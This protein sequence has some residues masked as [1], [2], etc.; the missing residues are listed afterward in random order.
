MFKDKQPYEIPNELLVKFRITLEGSLLYTL[1]LEY[2]ADSFEE[3]V[4]ESFEERFA[5]KDWNEI[6][7][8]L[9]LQIRSKKKKAWKEQALKNYQERNEIYPT[10]LNKYYFEVVETMEKSKM[11]GILSQSS[12]SVE[13]LMQEKIAALDAWASDDTKP[14]TDYPFL[15]DKHKRSIKRAILDDIQYSFLHFLKEEWGKETGNDKPNKELRDYPVQTQ[16]LFDNKVHR[17]EMTFDGEVTYEGEVVPYKEL[18]PEKD[19]TRMIV[20]EPLALKEMVEKLGITDSIKDLDH[21]D[22]EIISSVL[23]KRT[24]SFAVN[25]TIQLSLNDIVTDVFTSDSGNNYRNLAQ[26]MINLTK[27][28]FS[29]LNKEN[30]NLRVFG[31]FD[32]I[33]F[34]GE[35][36]MQVEVIINKA[37]HDAYINK[38]T[39]RIYREQLEKLEMTMWSFLLFIQK[40]RITAH[41]M[42]RKTLEVTLDNF[43]YNLR[44]KSKRKKEIRDE[45]AASLE[46]LK[47][48]KL[49]IE[50][51][52]YNRD[53]YYVTFIPMDDHE[54]HDIVNFG[55]KDDTLNLDTI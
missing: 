32:Y 55:S 26:R 50:D 27:M 33:E 8:Y 9:R 28:T 3:K 46:I 10:E 25:S 4:S 7:S 31:I 11:L 36:N 22:R 30:G 51:Y 18:G 40:E 53:I 15:K 54:V 44:F 21:Y 23:N 16:L 43:R 6:E 29:Q 13:S 19:D 47:K 34:S 45:I 49:L 20:R 14:L 35:N 37:I 52:K 12:I 39:L 17:K 2:F 1:F 38:Q 48:Q 24:E 5:D 41:K 42:E